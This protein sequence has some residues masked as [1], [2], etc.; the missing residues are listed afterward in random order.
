[1]SDRENQ[2]LTDC[3]FFCAMIRVGKAP[4][5]FLMLLSF[6]INITLPFVKIVGELWLC[7]CCCYYYY[8]YYYYCY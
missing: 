4:G 8:Y 5:A 3:R 2:V 7:S 6:N 1:M